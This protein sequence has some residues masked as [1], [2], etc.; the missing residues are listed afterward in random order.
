MFD[1]IRFRLRA[2][3]RPYTLE[4]EMQN[5]MQSH[6]D[7][8]I[9][10]LVG[11][12]MSPEVARLA[13]RREFG[14]VGVHQEQARDARRT[15]WIDGIRTDI[16]FAFRSFARK[17]F[18]SVTIVLVLALGIGAH[19][20][21]LTGIRRYT[22]R[23]APGMSDDVDLVRLRGMWRPKDQTDWQ[24]LAFSYPELHEISALRN[25]FASV[26]AWTKR[27]VVVDAAGALDRAQ[28]EANF[29]TDGFFGVLGLRPTLGAGLPSG[30]Q[31]PQLVAVISHTMWQDVFESAEDVGSRTF[32]VN[33]VTVRIV[34]WPT[35]FSAGPALVR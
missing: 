24:G 20:F 9:E 12:G 14:N 11:Q 1:R 7:R 17:P 2:L 34:G 26:A 5:E 23:R 8:R 10:T 29:V 31:D 27:D 28:G 13:A 16:R 32:D 33:G 19:A 4:Q 18:M 6:L 35:I 30:Q 15:S 25:T 21:E 3:F 22:S